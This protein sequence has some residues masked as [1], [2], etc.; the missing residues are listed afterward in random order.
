LPAASA[1]KLSGKAVTIARP[2]TNIQEGYGCGYSND[3]DSVQIEV[4]V[5]TH[6]PALSYDTFVSGTK[7]PKVVAGLGDKAFFDND[8]TM[9]VL[10]GNNLIQVN[11]VATAEQCAAVARPIVAALVRRV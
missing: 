2:L 4:T 3:D 9:Y 8:G 6:N 5:F 10:A 11:G 7:N 1:A